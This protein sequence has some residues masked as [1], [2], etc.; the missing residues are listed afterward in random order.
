MRNYAKSILFFV[1]LLTSL[2]L[3]ESFIDDTT[4]EFNLGDYNQITSSDNNLRL[5]IETG[6]DY[7]TSGDFNSDIFDAIYDVN[8]TNITW[9]GD[10]NYGSHLPINETDAFDA[11][12]SGNILNYYF[13]QNLAD[14]LITEEYDYSGNDNNHTFDT[15]VNVFGQ[16]GKIGSTL[17]FDESV[18]GLHTGARTLLGTNNF[19]QMV[20]IYPT[21]IGV[22][23]QS[24]GFYYLSVAFD[25]DTYY[26]KVLLNDGS[27]N[28]YGSKTETPIVLN[29]WQLITVVKDETNGL[30]VYKNKTLLQNYND[31]HTI[32][33]LSAGYRTYVNS[34]NYY[35]GMGN[36]DE[37][38]Y[39]DINIAYSDINTIFDDEN[40]GTRDTTT[41][42]ANRQVEL[43]FEELEGYSLTDSMGN[44]NFTLGGIY[45][46]SYSSSGK[47]N[48]TYD[49]NYIHGDCISVA[50][51]ASNSPTT[52]VTISAWLK[53]RRLTTVNL[54]WK[55]NNFFFDYASSS[56]RFRVYNSSGTYASASASASLI[57]LNNWHHI[58]GTYDGSNV[59]LYVD[60]SLIDSD[61]LTGNIRDSASD[62]YIACRGDYFTTPYVSYDG[63]M[64]EVA[65]WDRALSTTEIEKIY[66]RGTMDMKL[67]A[68]TCSTS[69]CSSDPDFI[70]PDGTNSS[71]YIDDNLAL[72]LNVSNNR[73]FQY[74]TYFSTD[75]N[76]YTPYLTDVNITYEKTYPVPV[77]V[78]AILSDDN[79]VQTYFKID[80][81][82]RIYT[83][84]DNNALAPPLITIADS[85]TIAWTTNASMIQESDTNNYYYDLDLNSDMN[86]GWFDLTIYGVDFNYLFY[87]S[88]IW[89]NYY[90]DLD[91]NTYPFSIDFNVSEDNNIER[92]YTL[93]NQDFNFTYDASQNSIRVIYLHSD[94]NYLEVPSQVYDVNLNSS[95]VNNATVTFVDS[96]DSNE[97]RQY[98]L[99]YAKE[100]FTKNYSTDLDYSVDSNII[101][102][103]NEMYSLN[104]DLEKGGLI[105][106]STQKELAQSRDFNS[107]SY[108]S[109]SP[110]VSTADA[111]SYLAYDVSDVNVSLD[112]NGPLIK[113]YKVIGST[114]TNEIDFNILYT[115]YSKLPYAYID[116]NVL[117]KANENWSVYD[118]YYVK[119]NPVFTKYSYLKTGSLTTTT[120]DSSTTGSGT[121]GIT[122]INYFGIYNPTT[123]AGF[124]NVFVSQTDTTGSATYSTKLWDNSSDEWVRRTYFSSGA[125]TTSDLFIS[126]HAFVTFNAFNNSTDLNTTYYDITNAVSVSFGSE[127]SFD[128]TDPVLSD[129]NYT[130]YP[131]VYD[132][133][134]PNCSAHI[135]DNLDVDYVILNVLGPD[136]N[137]TT[138]LQV[139]DNQTA[140]VNYDF[141]VNAGDYNCVFT[142]YDISTNTDLNYVEF[143]VLDETAPNFNTVSSTPDTNTLV[144]PLTVVRVDAN[145]SE[146]TGIGDN[147]VI[148]YYR[149]SGGSWDTNTMN[150]TQS[151]YLFDCNASF[152]TDS[153]E[154]VYEY[155]VYANDLNDND[156]N[157]DTNTIYSYYDWTWTISSDF[158]TNTKSGG[159]DENISVGAITITNTGDKNLLFSVSSDWDVL[160]KEEIY[161]NAN[162]EGS[163]GYDFNVDYDNNLDL[164]LIITAKES[165]EEDDIN[166]AINAT[167][168]SADPTIEYLS[169]TIVSYDGNSPWL[170]GN[171]ITEDAAVTREDTNINYVLRVSNVG[172]QDCNSGTLIWSL[173]TG[174][175]MT[176]GDNNSSFSL[177]QN[178]AS[179]FNIFVSV[180]SSASLG[181]NTLSAT[182]ECITP[183]TNSWTKSSSITVSGTT[184]SSGSSGGGGSGSS[185]GGGSATAKDTFVEE[186][187]DLYEIKKEF[188]QVDNIFK[189]VRG[190]TETFILK[191]SNPFEY[192]NLIDINIE[193]SGL[194]TKYTVLT[195]NE[196][197]QLGI[198]EFENIYLEISPPKYLEKGESK[199]DIKISGKIE[200]I[201]NDIVRSVSEFE[202]SV[203]IIIKIFEIEKEDVEYHFEVANK[204]ISDLRNRGFFVGTLVSKFKQAELYYNGEKIEDAKALL[205][206]IESAQKIA[207]LVESKIEK[208]QKEIL[209]VRPFLIE[210]PETERLMISAANALTRGDFDAAKQLIDEAEIVF[211]LETKGE[212]SI[213]YYLKEYWY[214]LIL[215]F[216]IMALVI[217]ISSVLI[218]RRRLLRKLS[219]LKKEEGIFIHLIRDAQEKCFNENKMSVDEYKSLVE[220]LEKRLNNNLQ[221]QISIGYKLRYFKNTRKALVEE[222]KELLQKMQELQQNYFYKNE[223]TS[224]AY[225]AKFKNL[226]K[227]IGEIEADLAKIDFKR[228]LKKYKSRRL[229]HK[230]FLES[231]KLKEEKVLKKNKK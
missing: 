165:A 89:T 1:L 171:F 46:P 153:A 122:D 133:N 52:E 88:P 177:T 68:R 10:I 136:T 223:L 187:F 67:Q 126:R 114:G 55:T 50:D 142:A 111:G 128:S 102:F 76:S 134:T 95:Y 154:A 209:K 182:Y 163:N 82:V 155:Y 143:T 26:I 8:W 64:D 62:L 27:S 167:D 43:R 194:L 105:T 195:V 14:S 99:A 30:S 147:N 22:I 117:P 87:K 42:L 226:I 101:S 13:D 224:W 19:T 39:F 156:A 125:V 40:A 180:S 191:L 32:A 131:T 45:R 181:V 190:K 186:N 100:S 139:D 183:D 164:N 74:K 63:L 31:A 205:L 228:E 200:G 78:K 17:K 204:I 219:L 158:D 36:I 25:T 18:Y 34:S 4:I 103:S 92:K 69:T 202:E 212:L 94:G 148:L 231:K 160:R 86:A 54:F 196:I 110:F 57:S 91:S 33:D 189:V 173:P 129:L 35:D 146:Y 80:D 93:I 174:F 107:S 66:K 170:Y 178:S 6:T 65:M 220:H 198:G 166:I 60:G 215:I 137:T 53:P 120:V 141:N 135:T 161:Y 116:I 127:S 207:Y 72:D 169:A 85:N 21:E 201:K 96:F 149:K 192:S 70:G 210:T 41:Q 157:S 218:Y 24:Q 5:S 138:T 151:S 176:T 56:L 20:W 58:V 59:N 29:E 38:K 90:T 47:V 16:T 193:L 71:Y 179:D 206:E 203:E 140:D 199:I 227:R 7:Y 106:Y 225:S 214:H 124:G 159:Y 98:K 81:T 108:F 145:I 229:A 104:L 121:S 15:D 144:D 130:P 3:A 168:S 208:L 61:P 230:Q 79:T 49:F 217:S 77:S 2:V 48:G 221:S 75:D 109:Y 113:K 150:C 211:A 123:Y 37:L 162:S 11:N 119:L 84:T 51:S 73:Y 213:E 152:T 12:M 216:V 97:A 112:V 222:K 118:D 172:S 197:E 185:G 28:Y 115:F 184:S 175:T 83:E 44:S 23:L 132:V 188:L 9:T